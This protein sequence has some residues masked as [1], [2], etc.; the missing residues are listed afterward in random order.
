MKKVIVAGPLV[1][2]VIYPIGSSHDSP[3][4]RGGKRRL[5]C[6]TQQRMNAIYS[7]QKLELML[8]ANYLPGDLVIVLTYLLWDEATPAGGASDLCG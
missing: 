4:A 5:S 3:R 7:W 2:E 1:K 8:A 6:E